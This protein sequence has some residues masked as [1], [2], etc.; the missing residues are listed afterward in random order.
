MG[1]QRLDYASPE[2]GRE[3]PICAL[4][5]A[6]ATGAVLSLLAALGFL[7]QI[8][9][10]APNFYYTG[11]LELGVVVVT[12][13]PSAILAACSFF[14]PLRDHTP[15]WCALI[16]LAAAWATVIITWSIWIT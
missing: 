15:A 10:A 5:A 9:A 16:L 1:E 13:I 8:A 7:A 14:R 4:G 12:S 2:R 11:V 6:A 3:Q